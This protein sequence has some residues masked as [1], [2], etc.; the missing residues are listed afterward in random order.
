MTPD[1]GR[2]RQ[3]DIKARGG[4]RHVQ[5]PFG[6]PVQIVRQSERLQRVIERERQFG[7]AVAVA[8]KFGERKKGGMLQQIVGARRWYPPQGGYRVE[9][10]AVDR[11][12]Q[13]R[14]L[15]V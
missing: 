5:R 14:R 7:A 3:G 2:A 8:A 13:R 15:A 11:H 1:G 6:A 4:L 9:K 12:R 10:V